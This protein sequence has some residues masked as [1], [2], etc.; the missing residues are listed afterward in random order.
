M[1]LTGD[2]FVSNLDSVIVL[3]LLTFNFIPQRSYYSL[4]LPRSG[5]RTA[6]TTLMRLDD[7]TDNKVESSA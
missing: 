5:P 2:A 7:T 6:T 1:G 4:A 3:V